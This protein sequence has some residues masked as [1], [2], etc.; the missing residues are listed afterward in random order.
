MHPS[1]AHSCE[2]VRRRRAFYRKPRELVD[3]QDRPGRRWQIQQRIPVRASIGLLLFERL[4]NHRDWPR[5][6]KGAAE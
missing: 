2:Q 1:H 5:A 6:G 4:A 3:R